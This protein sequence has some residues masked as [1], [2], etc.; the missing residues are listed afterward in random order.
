MDDALPNCGCAT[1]TTI[2]A[3]TPMNRHTCAD[4]ATAPRAG[5]DA[6]DNRTTDAYRNGCSAMAKT[7]A[8]TTAT[9]CPK[10]VRRATPTPTSSAPTIDAFQSM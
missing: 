8:A 7:I 2:A 1:S 5:N 3:T 9:N 10:T 4:N 6:P